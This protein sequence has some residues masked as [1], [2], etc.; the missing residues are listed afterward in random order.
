MWTLSADQLAHRLAG[1]HQLDG[2]AIL[3]AIPGVQRNAEGVIDGRGQVLRRH[4]A[5]DDELAQG[6]GAA[7]DLAGADAA[8]AEA[9]TRRPWPSDRG[10]PTD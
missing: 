3:G 7:D 6:I 1:R 2:P 8:A 4:R 5:V 9:G 10:P